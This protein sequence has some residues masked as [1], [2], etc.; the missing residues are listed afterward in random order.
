MASS[1]MTGSLASLPNSG[2]GQ[3]FTPRS[4]ANPLGRGLR[5]RLHPQTL[6]A[7]RLPSPYDR[8]PLRRRAT[9]FALAAAINLAL[10]LLLIGMGVV[11]APPKPG[12]STLTVDLMPQSRNSSAEQQE[13]TT[14]K[15]RTRAPS[16]KPP[17]I[18]LPSKPTIASPSPSTTPWIEMSKDE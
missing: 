2:Q 3:D 12:S 17:P 18:V 6:P 13:K 9:S 5:D 14:V 7:Y 16:R 8:A 4:A 11:K 10:L 1:S 15:P